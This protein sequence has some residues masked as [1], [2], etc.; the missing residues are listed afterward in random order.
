MRQNQTTRGYSAAQNS[1]DGGESY[2]VAIDGMGFAADVSVG[3][4]GAGG[5]A[6]AGEEFGLAVETGFVAED[7]EVAAETLVGAGFGGC[8]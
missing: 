6:G 8:G 2:K 3:S 1:G 5:V 4:A 7:D